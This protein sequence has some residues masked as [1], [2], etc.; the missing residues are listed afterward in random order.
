MNNR[1]TYTE[2]PHKK[3][4][5]KLNDMEKYTEMLHKKRSKN[6]NNRGTNTETPHNTKKGNIILTTGEKTQK[7][8]TKKGQRI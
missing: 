2:M 1:V 4:S 3:R 7:C 8:L 6:L 5:K